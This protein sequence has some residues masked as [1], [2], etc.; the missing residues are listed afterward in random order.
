MR[1]PLKTPS[2]FFQR[3]SQGL[4]KLIFLCASGLYYLL[5][6]HSSLL[7]ICQISTKNAFKTTLF[8]I[9]QISPQTKIKTKKHR[10]KIFNLQTKKTDKSSHH[11]TSSRLLSAKLSDCVE[12]RETPAATTSGGGIPNTPKGGG[13]TV[14]RYSILFNCLL[15][16]FCMF[17]NYLCFFQY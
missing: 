7:Q 10:Q 8:H 5:W 6:N 16:I 9:C 4:E 1:P 3:L 11:N 2:V 12:V 17:K 15:M 13:K 14:V